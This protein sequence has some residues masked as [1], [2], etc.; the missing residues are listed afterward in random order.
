MKVHFG[1]KN[2][3]SDVDYNEIASLT[4]GFSGADIANL[5]NEAAIF[6][7]RSNSEKI[8]RTNILDAYEKITI[9]LVSRTQ[10]A[11]KDVIELVS[12][13]EIGHALMV[14]KFKDL[15]DLRKV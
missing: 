15:F 11:D 9:G 14:A 12:N 4:P 6:S 13:H 7:V 5:A 10:T 2:V 3:E 8:T 1:N